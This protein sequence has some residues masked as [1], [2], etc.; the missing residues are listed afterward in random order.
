MIIRTIH[1]MR[2]VSKRSN[3]I[4]RIDMKYLNEGLDEYIKFDQ[5]IGLVRGGEEAL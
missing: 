2:N 1:K 4:I 5:D 3:L